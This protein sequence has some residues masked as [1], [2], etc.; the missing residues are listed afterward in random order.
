[1][2]HLPVLFVSCHVEELVSQGGAITGPSRMVW[3]KHYDSVVMVSMAPPGTPDTLHLQGEGT[4]SEKILSLLKRHG[5]S[6]VVHPEGTGERSLLLNILLAQGVKELIEIRLGTGMGLLDYRDI[7]RCLAV[8]R[9]QGTLV[10][11]LDDTTGFSCNRSGSTHNHYLRKILGRWAQGDQCV[12]SD[13]GSACCLSDPSAC[14]LNIAFAMGGS[15]FPQRIFSSHMSQS[16]STVF[17]YG[18]LR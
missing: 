13:M 8:M 1:M 9:E 14:L 10:I 2:N 12:P 18:W 16:R 4:V 6:P 7:G 5:L 3:G 11:G 17:G 15:R